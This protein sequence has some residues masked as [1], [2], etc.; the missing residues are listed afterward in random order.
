MHAKHAPMTKFSMFGNFSRPP[1][2]TMSFSLHGCPRRHLP[3]ALL[4]H[5]LNRGHMLSWENAIIIRHSL[6]RTDLVQ[7]IDVTLEASVVDLA[8]ENAL[9]DSGV[10]A[11][12]LRF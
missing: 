10:R 6:K 9:F 8:L 1:P 2:S 12:F 5:F 3:Q 11:P 7:R 4:L